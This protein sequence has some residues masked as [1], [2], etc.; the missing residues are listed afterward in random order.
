MQGLIDHHTKGLVDRGV[1]QHV[2]HQVGP[3][4]RS[5]VTQPLGV[6][7]QAR[8][9]GREFGFAGTAPNVNVLPFNLR[10]ALLKNA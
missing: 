4:S 7:A 10:M 1:R 3:G 8:G 2:D 6:Y 9:V 5:A